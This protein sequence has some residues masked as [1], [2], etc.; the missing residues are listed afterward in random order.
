VTKISAI[1][2]QANVSHTRNRLTF[3]PLPCEIIYLVA[4]RKPR[5]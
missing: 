2:S 5:Y 4:L 3:S 1:S